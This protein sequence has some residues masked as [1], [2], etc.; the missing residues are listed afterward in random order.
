MS[1]GGWN[2]F[3]LYRRKIPAI[4]ESLEEKSYSNYKSRMESRRGG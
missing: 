3:F 2:E 4:Q 1:A